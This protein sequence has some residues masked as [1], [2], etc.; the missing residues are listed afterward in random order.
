MPGPLGVFWI[1]EVAA[2]SNESLKSETHV[3]GDVRAVRMSDH[4][5]VNA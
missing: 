2:G 3:P 1:F 4:W 5:E